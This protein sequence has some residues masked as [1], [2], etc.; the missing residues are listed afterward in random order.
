MEVKFNVTGK[1]R[2]H[3]AQILGEVTG[4]EVKYLGV[5]SCNYAVSYFTIDR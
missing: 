4:A 1:E 5:P 3:L 2:K